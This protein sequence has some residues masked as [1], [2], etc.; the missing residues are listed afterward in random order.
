MS[1][2]RHRA[3]RKRARPRVSWA[4]VERVRRTYGDLAALVYFLEESGHRVTS[5]AGRL[6][7]ARLFP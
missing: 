5:A 1:R 6:T 7:S 3:A 4:A 2:D